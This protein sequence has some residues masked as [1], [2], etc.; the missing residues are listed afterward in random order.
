MT[1]RLAAAALAALLPAAVVTAVIACGSDPLPPSPPPPPPPGIQALKV[2][3]FLDSTGTAPFLGQGADPATVITA[4]NYLGVR[5]LRDTSG[6][7]AKMINV[8]TQTN[9]KFLYLIGAG[10]TPNLSSKIT[11]SKA[12]QA[13]GKLI[14]VEGANEPNN[15]LVTWEGV[16]GGGSLSWVPVARL[17]RDFYNLVKATPELAGVP[18]LNISGSGA[19]FDNVGLQCLVLDSSC[20]GAAT[21]TL[22]PAGTKYG[23]IAN[24]HPYFCRDPAVDNS[25]WLAFASDTVS[26][27]PDKLYK[28]YQ[29]TW[30]QHFTGYTAAQLPGLRRWITETGWQ[31]AGTSCVTSPDRQGKWLLN[32]FLSAYKQGWE[33]T[34]IFSLQD[35]QGQFFGYYV[36]T[37]PTV[38]TP[39]PAAT[40][41]HNMTTILADT[42]SAFTA[43]AVPYSITNLPAYGHDLLLQKSN[44]KY[45]LVVWGEGATASSSVTVNLGSQR[46]NVT[47]YDPTIGT[48]A[49][50]ILGSVT[51]VP[52]T[53][54]DHPFIIEFN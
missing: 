46:T 17:T 38:Y 32:A 7:S 34:F 51:S 2:N 54:S 16:Q 13:A 35:W 1:I 41:L 30:L 14:A 26:A 24:V 50:Q 22:M 28:S 4:V 11:I 48:A 21:V 53:V 33:K 5:N 25:A 40:F 9:T 43:G 6:D 31:D 29:N 20:P 49:T 3:D 37:S 27:V 42:S 36:I 47:V 19:E 39:K 15:F 10:G 44:G 52:L 23:D 18:V 8:A 12:L 45:E